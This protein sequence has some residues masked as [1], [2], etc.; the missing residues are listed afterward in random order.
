MNKM[1]A[2]YHVD[3]AGPYSMYSID[4]KSESEEDFLAAVKEL[5]YPLPTSDI[6]FIKD[7]KVITQYFL[8]EEDPYYVDK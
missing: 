1:I 5:E 2:V 3:F 4:V 6:I 7:N 8:G